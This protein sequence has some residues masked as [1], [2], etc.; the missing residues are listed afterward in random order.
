MELNTKAPIAGLTSALGEVQRLVIGFFRYHTT[1][2][3]C[4]VLQVTEERVAIFT[5]N[6][7][8]A[9]MVQVIP[10][11]LGILTLFEPGETLYTL[12]TANLAKLQEYYGATKSKAA[13]RTKGGSYMAINT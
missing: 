12:K 5:L 1:T 11:K 7:T 8:L 6:D 2:Q 13:L 4:L 3:I 10:K 9:T